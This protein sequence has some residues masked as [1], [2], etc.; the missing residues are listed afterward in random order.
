MVQHYTDFVVIC[1]TRFSPR[2]RTNIFAR[3]NS[4][5]ISRRRIFLRSPSATKHFVALNGILLPRGSRSISRRCSLFLQ[6]APSNMCAVG[7]LWSLI[8]V[9]PIAKQVSTCDSRQ[10]L[11][12]S[13]FAL[14]NQDDSLCDR[15]ADGTVSAPNNGNDVHTRT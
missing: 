14:L 4:G 10:V 8:A 13:L 1:T 15:M 11:L 7:S 9:S 6:F 3:A 12:S 2:V 5:V